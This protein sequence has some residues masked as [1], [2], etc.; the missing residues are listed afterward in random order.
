[1]SQAD[2]YVRIVTQNDTTEAQRS[3]ERLGDTIRDSMDT[4]PVDRMSRSLDNVQQGVEDTGSAAVTTGQLIKANLISDVI[5]QGVQQLGEILKNA[6][7]HTVEVADGVNSSVNKIAAATNASAEDMERLKGVVEQI[8][9]DNFGESFDDIADSV[10][11]VKQNLGDLDDKELVSVTESA[12]A[13]RDVFGYAVD[14]SSRAARAIVQNFNV[15]ADEAYDYIARGAQNGL[16]FSGELLDSIS[17]YSVHFKKLGLSIDDMFNIMQKGADS[18]AFKLDS[19][20]DAIKEVSI[21]AVDGSDTTKHAFETAGLSA[22]KMAEMFSKGGES[23]T[24]AFYMTIQALAE[25]DDPLQQDM[26]GVELF[27]T[28]WEDLSKD[29][30]L[31]MSDI[32]DSAYDCAG[33]MDGIKDVNYNDLSNSFDNVKRQIDL[34]IQPIGESLIPILDEAADTV[35][36]LAQEG[37]IKE[38]AVG[39]GNFISGTLTFLLK[40][41]DLILSAVTG[42]TAAVIAF[43]IANKLT[44]VIQSWQTAALQVKLFAASQRTAALQTA[45][46]TGQ[47]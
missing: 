34:L 35:A 4:S 40:N 5:M 9:G 7:V 39:V 33:A 14:E 36:E 15:S 32:S 10:A 44:G 19:I 37:D 2:G 20:G 47:L 8:Y 38:I 25:M 31:A 17:E 42:I 23:A 45:A 28:L 24:E 43:K 11:K 1:M 18:G 27:K 16:D 26:A 29:V 46:T 22:D 13:L 12:Y 30:V 21:N 6:A 41:L 3:T